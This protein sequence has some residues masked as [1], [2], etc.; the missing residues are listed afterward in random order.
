MDRR[1]Q[2]NQEAGIM[3]AQSWAGNNVAGQDL[4][5]RTAL[6]TGST[7]GIGEATAVALAQRGAHVLVTGRDAQR[8]AAVV[9]AIRADGGK[10]DFVQADLRDAASA[11]DL[12]RQATEAAGGRIDILVNNAGRGAVG[13]T[14]GF[15]ED[16]FDATFG[17]NV[18]A[19]FY[20]VG[21]IAPG[22]AE[23]GQGA[24]VNISTMA[25]QFGVPG[26]AVYGASKA[27]LNLM[28]K[29]WAAEFGPQ[30]VRVNAVSPG[31]TRTPGVQMMGDGL[32]QLAAQSPAGYVAAPEDIAAVVAFLASDE[33]RYVQG[34]LVNADGG[35][36]AV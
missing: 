10:A 33:A 34:A 23:R 5:E 28:T 18:K 16:V 17:T 22:M 26:M 4:S 31:P 30:G 24:I 21:A 2:N 3:A 35:R 27:A 13:A 14:A 8:G 20:L 19:P 6:V 12:A 7:S 29:S 9:D 36:T 1:I 11:Q 15:G 32:D 25:A